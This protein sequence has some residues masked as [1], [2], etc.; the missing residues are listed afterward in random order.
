MARRFAKTALRQRQS[1]PAPR[2]MLWQT[3]EGSAAE[4]SRTRPA[5]QT[6]TTRQL[7]KLD[8]TLLLR[9]QLR[10]L[11]R[12]APHDLDDGYDTTL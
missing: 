5:K 4:A 8:I 2:Q 12:Q 10:L 6:I 9:L 1:A 11:I 7:S 3:N